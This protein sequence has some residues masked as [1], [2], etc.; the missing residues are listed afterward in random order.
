MYLCGD[1]PLPTEYAFMP[2]DELLRERSARRSTSGCSWRS[3]VRTRRRLG[4]GPGVARARA[5]L[6]DIDHHHDNSRFGD[7]NLIVADAS[8]TGEIAPRRLRELG[9]ELTPRDRGGALHRPRH[10][11]RSLPVHEHDAEGAPAGGRA[12]RGRRRRP[13][14]LPGR[15]RDGRTSRSSSC[16]RGA[17]ER[18][19]VYEG[20]RLVV[21]YLAAR[22]ISS[23]SARRSRTPRASSTGCARS[24]APRWS[25]LDPRAAAGDGAA[26]RVSLRT[27]RR[28]DRRLGDRAQVGRGRAPP[29]GRLLE[30]AVDRGDHRVHPRRVRRACP[31]RRG[32]LARAASSWSTSRRA[33][34]RSRS[35]PTCGGGRARGRGTPGRSTR[36]LPGCCSCCPVRQLS[37]LDASSDWTSAT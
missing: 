25:A 16:S 30:R 21:S 10:G 27:S 7:V 28:R 13:P 1:A 31:C 24:R 23:S 17:L 4:P 18:A 12:G 9:V 20:G 35:S 32:R 22:A 34:R 8:S 15:V 36:S 29:G 37:W 19:K 6:V 5:A 26:R 3:T 11:H 2:L 33:P 14:D